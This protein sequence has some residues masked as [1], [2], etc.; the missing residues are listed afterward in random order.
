MRPVSHRTAAARPPSWRRAVRS[1]RHRSSGTATQPHAPHRRSQPVGALGCIGSHQTALSHTGPHRATLHP[2]CPR[3]S[4]RAVLSPLSSTRYLLPRLHAVVTCCLHVSPLHHRARAAEVPPRPA[5]DGTRRVHPI[6]PHQ[7]PAK[8]T[9][10]RAAAQ[11]HASHRRSQPVGAPGRIGSH[12]TAPDITGPRCTPPAP[13]ARTALFSLL[14]PLPATSCPGYTRWR[15]VACMYRRSTT[16]P[17]P[18]RS[19]QD[20]P[21]TA[22]AVSTRYSPTRCRAAAQPH[23]PH[24]RSWPVGPPGRIGSHQTAPDSTEPRCTPPAPAARTALFSLLCPL[25]A[26]YCPGYTRWRPVAC[27]CRRSTT[28]PGPPKGQPS[29]ARDSTRRVHPVQPHQVPAKPHQLP[30]RRPATCPASP[31]TASRGA[32]PH[33]VAPNSTRQHRAT[34]GR[35]SF[36]SAFDRR[37]HPEQPRSVLPDCPL[38]VLTRSPPPRPSTT[39]QSLPNHSPTTAQPQPNY[40]LLCARPARSTAAACISPKWPYAAPAR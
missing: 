34:S 7:V 21:E 16:A 37:S 38:S 35:T 20:P 17:G 14:C 10:C 24:R 23:A 32:G 3:C 4:H 1:Y 33:W 19:R 25:A 29:P 36:A 8:P 30:H 27:M 18:P 11:P 9:R 31:F 6:Q 28:A 12:Q 39:T 22:H 15:P 26:T 13:A 5:R 2:A 40:R